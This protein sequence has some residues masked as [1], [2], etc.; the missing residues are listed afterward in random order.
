MD[1][2]I[3]CIKLYKKFTNKSFM[4]FTHKNVSSFVII[5]KRFKNTEGEIKN[6]K[7]RETGTK[8]YTRRRQRKQNYNTTSVGHNE[9]AKASPPTDHKIVDS[10][11]VLVLEK[12]PNQ[13]KHNQ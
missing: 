3:S 2:W 5:N 7:S 12:H 4:V 11:F 6:G 9:Q 10:I 1:V 13:N 8:W